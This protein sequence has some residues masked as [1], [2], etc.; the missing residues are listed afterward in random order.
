SACGDLYINSSTGEQCEPPNTATCDALCHTIVPVVCGDN[1]LATSEQCDDNNGTPHNLD[2]CDT[3]CKYEMMVRMKSMAIS[4]STS[5]A[6]CTPT[7]NT[8]GRN[9]VA[10]TTALNTLNDALA[11]GV[12]DGSMNLILQF[13]ELDDL[14]G[15][16]DSSIRLGLMTG[17]L[18]PARGT[19][20]GNNPIDWWYMISQTNLDTNDLP[21]SLFTTAKITSRQIEAGPSDVTMAISMGG[22]PASLLMR[23][24]RVFATV[25]SSAS[26]PPTPPPSWLTTG[27]STFESI[28]AT[29]SGKGMCGNITVESLSRIPVPEA[30]T[31]GA[32]ACKS[33]GTNSK[34]YTYCGAG[35]PVGPDCNSLL[36]VI[37]GGCRVDF[38]VSCVV[39][40]INKTQPDVAGPGGEQGT[41]TIDTANHNKVPESQVAGNT[42][43]YSA[44][45]TFTANRAH[46]TGKKP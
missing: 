38:I 34:V 24:A 35:N 37:I 5:P 36:D 32:G 20:P 29:A 40:V 21:K 33:C 16:N 39:Q 30:L 17:D 41:I 43:G 44:A 11:E 42:R 18:D 6:G 3:A 28:S 27:L 22:S 13:L 25:D 12:N 10:N 31:T 19:W 45:F 14:T 4:A 23:S 26:V 7:T 8:F 1:L 46:A 15:I 2:G 9:V